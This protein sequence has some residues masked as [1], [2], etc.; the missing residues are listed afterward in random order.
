MSPRLPEQDLR[1]DEG[2]MLA[3]RNGDAAA[4]E[5]LYGRWRRQLFRYLVHQCGQDGASDELFQDVWLRVV[6]ARQQY[7][8][9]APFHAWLFR[10][11]HNRLVDYWRSTN[12]SPIQDMSSPDDEEFDFMVTVPAPDDTRPDR[13]A[14]RKEQAAH[15]LAAVQSLPDAQR[16]TFILAEDGGL[17]LEE[18]AS[19][20]EVG[21]ET[22]K[23]RLRYAVGKLRLELSKWR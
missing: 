8:V 9:S 7:E 1:T 5:V 12:R 15:L 10:I 19:V 22:V 18:I 17:S 21:R 4:F 23:S 13:Q 11:A 20:M 16:E 14:E 3:Y 2:L 6:N